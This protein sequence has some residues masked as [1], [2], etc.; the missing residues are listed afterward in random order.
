MRK[1]GKKYWYYRE[2]AIVAEAGTAR[3][4]PH[5]AVTVLVYAVLGFL[6]SH[7]LIFAI[8]RWMPD[9]GRR[10][11]LTGIL[12]DLSTLIPMALILFYTLTVERRPLASMG[13]VCGKPMRTYLITVGIIAAFALVYGL[14]VGRGPA[15]V[16]RLLSGESGAMSTDYGGVMLPAV[17]I[18]GSISQLCGVV[19]MYGFMLI[20]LANRMRMKHAVIAA[21]L[22][23]ILLMAVTVASA[24]INGAAHGLM[25][26]VFQGICT[27]V[28]VA[29][30]SLLLLRT[31]SIWNVAL[32]ALAKNM[33]LTLSMSQLDT[34]LN[35]V[36]II[37]IVAAAIIMILRYP[38]NGDVKH[39]I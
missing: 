10:M 3:R 36:M 12:T 28:S 31:G 29:A 25:D 14:T 4:K 18:T 32:F 9:P 26:T 38:E 2:P 6:L 8:F 13:I 19:M 34:P 17:F 5:P 24:L 7:L 30:C 20:S 1:R 22:L 33:L 23:P 35:Y 37:M 11:E 15:T 16:I 27:S 21:S 39:Y